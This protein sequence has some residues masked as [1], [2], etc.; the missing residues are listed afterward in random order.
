MVSKTQRRPDQ[1][2]L[3]SNRLELGCALLESPGLAQTDA[4]L[5]IAL[6]LHRGARPAPEP[7]DP[8]SGNS[9]TAAR[10]HLVHDG[11]RDDRLCGSASD[12]TVRVKRRISLDKKFS[13]GLLKTI[14]SLPKS[15]RVEA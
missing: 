4:P 13:V 8:R 15:P 1:L 2:S 11:T 7:S 6:G 9:A 14:F 10:D 12:R 3:E 5:F